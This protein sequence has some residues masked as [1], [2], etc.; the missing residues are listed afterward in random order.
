MC[1]KEGMDNDLITP[2][3]KDEPKKHYKVGVTPSI[4][5]LVALCDCISHLC[6]LYIKPL[7]CVATC[8][9]NQKR[10][11]TFR[12]TRAE[13]DAGLTPAAAREQ[14]R[15][16]SS[17][18]AMGSEVSDNANALLTHQVCSEVFGDA[19]PVMNYG[20]DEV[21]AA[22]QDEVSVYSFI[23]SITLLVVSS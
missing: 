2:S 20:S 4:V 23:I 14:R 12:R 3:G 22:L 15:R 5:N 16:R 13:I 11:A 1:R 8:L 19:A 10:K 6:M 9:L 17:N 7:K 21:T 18:A